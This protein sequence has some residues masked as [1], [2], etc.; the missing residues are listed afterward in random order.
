MTP[1]TSYKS[2]FS[3]LVAGLAGINLVILVHE[4][5]HFVCA[6]YFGVPATIF[7]LGFGPALIKIPL[8]ETIFQIAL[9]P[10]GG[11]V[12]INETVLATQPYLHK[13]AIMLAGILCNFIFTYAVF[14][15][16]APRQIA[17]KK[18][19]SEC[20]DFIRK[21]NGDHSGIIGPIGL[22]GIIGKCF[23]E[24]NTFFWLILGLISLNIGFFNLIP[25]PFFDGGKALIFTIEA[26]T[27]SPIS[28]NSMSIISMI[29]LSL[30]VVLAAAVSVNDVKRFK[31]N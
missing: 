31:Q 23:Q 26:A 6:Y 30:F 3:L 18:S 1:Q 13:M 8:G 16:F 19:L 7:S 22:I 2:K 20:L 21:E 10:F 17:E 14:C 28:E 27:G 24:N 12:E 29:I 9:L 25:L 4:L 5:G 15:F 11:Y